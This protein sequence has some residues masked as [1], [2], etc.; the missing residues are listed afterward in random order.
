MVRKGQRKTPRQLLGVDTLIGSGGGDTAA[1]HLVAAPS[2]QNPSLLRSRPSASL[3]ALGF[4]DTG[5]PIS[6]LDD[7]LPC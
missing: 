7:D 2:G 1:G 6:K 5:N 4:D 3:S